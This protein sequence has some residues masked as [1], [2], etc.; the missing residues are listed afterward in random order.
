MAKRWETFKNKEI[1]DFANKEYYI[2]I[3]TNLEVFKKNV[4]SILFTANIKNENETRVSVNT[5]FYLARAG[6]KVL[7][8]DMDFRK[9]RLSNLLIGN[10]ELNGVTDYFSENLPINDVLYETEIFNIHFIP[11]GRTKST[12]VDL[13]NRNYLKMLIN[14]LE[15]IYDYII[16]NCAPMSFCSDAMLLS[17]ICNG[18]VLVTKS[19]FVRRDIVLDNLNILRKSSNEFLG[20]ILNSVDM[21]EATYGSF[22]KYKN[23]GKY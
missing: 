4:K 23:F 7:L 22:G 17:S 8:V 18:T 15:D 14:G 11:L 10:A 3:I 1:I 5:A 13:L 19:N 12:A 2:D 6:F 16:I 9:R 20:I 21:K